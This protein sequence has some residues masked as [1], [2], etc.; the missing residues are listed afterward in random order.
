[1]P[2]WFTFPFK[3]L[4]KSKPASRAMAEASES[5]VHSSAKVAEKA[6]K[7]AA[8][9]DA[10]GAAKLLEQA[11]KTA[12]EGKALANTS[13]LSEAEKLRLVFWAMRKLWKVTVSFLPQQE[14]FL[15]LPKRVRAML[16]SSGKRSSASTTQRKGLLSL[17]WMPSWVMAVINMRLIP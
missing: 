13:T 17:V 16:A 10:A 6:S 4:S 11:S 12:Q 14:C 1:M 15:T 7:L 5:L 2:G 3:A 8:K 9:G